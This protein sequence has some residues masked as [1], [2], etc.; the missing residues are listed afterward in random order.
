MFLSSLYLS[1]YRSIDGGRAFSTLEIWSCVFQSRVF[2]HPFSAVS[3]GL[4][5]RGIEKRVSFRPLRIHAKI[6][7]SSV[8]ALLGTGLG[9]LPAFRRLGAA[10][11]A[12]GL[13][14]VMERP[15]IRHFAPPPIGLPPSN[16]QRRQLL[17]G[18]G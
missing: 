4:P 7:A 13:D 12:S 16:D 6:Y 14:L 10:A 1:I 11:S 15:A 9:H 2:S 17:P 3:S 18:L 8:L 5:A